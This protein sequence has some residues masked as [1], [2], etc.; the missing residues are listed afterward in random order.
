MGLVDKNSG[1]FSFYLEE[2]DE[3]DNE[4]K[5]TKSLT[6]NFEAEDKSV[7]VSGISICPFGSNEDEKNF[8]KLCSGVYDIWKQLPD[9]IYKLSTLSEAAI[10]YLYLTDSSIDSSNVTPVLQYSS[11]LLNTNEIYGKTDMPGS[12][13]LD[14]RNS[15]YKRI[16]NIQ[17]EKISI[18]AKNN[19]LNYEIVK[20]P[21]K[22]LLTVFLLAP[23]PG[24]YDFEVYYD[25]KDK[26]DNIFTYY[27]SCGFDKKLN[28]VNVENLSNG[29]YAF[30]K[31]L[32]SKD[33]E[34][35]VQYN[36]N[37][38]SVKEY[39]NNLF[40]AKDFN[41]NN[42]KIE[43]FYNKMSNTFIFYFDNHVADSLKLSSPIIKFYNNKE[44]ENISLTTNILDENHFS[45]KFENNKLKITPLNANYEVPDKTNMGSHCAFCKENL[46]KARNNYSCKS[47]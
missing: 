23:K 24:K 40:S 6:F 35:N 26:L 16:D 47:I 21:E 19:S 8:F 45:V 39:A 5:E 44:S 20:G 43:T 9:G 31:V 11:V 17:Q 30:F 41:N 34:C 4:Y 33:N 12:F 22:G 36:W 37:D 3:Y 14:L 18:H 38:L 7:D 28:H 32:D 42:Y 46:S 29:N 10:F 15:N 13:I 27:C 1:Y 2:R 25:N